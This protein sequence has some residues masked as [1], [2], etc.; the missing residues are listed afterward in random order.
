M[1]TELMHEDLP[2][3]VAPDTSTWGISARLTITARPAI[4]RPRATSRG[5]TA[6]V[7]LRRGQDVAQGHQLPA[8][9]GH[10]HPD[11]RLARDGSQ[12]PDVGRGHGVGDVLRQAT[13]PGPPSRPAPSSSSYRVTVGPTV[14]PTRRVSTPWADR[15]ATRATPPASTSRSSTAWGLACF[16]NVA[17]GSRQSPTVGP[18]F[19]SSCDPLTGWVARRRDQDRSVVG[20]GDDG[21]EL[22]LGRPVGASATTSAGLRR[23]D[24]TDRSVG[25]RRRCRPR[26]PRQVRPGPPR[27]PSGR[28]GRPRRRPS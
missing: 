23:R 28:R 22:G 3:P 6:F 2:E 21:I 25:R 8:A 26:G 27:R 16:S 20:V 17:G 24:R 14:R 4:S 15:A 12:D 1:S 19:I 13:S 7:G 10:L 5:W 11:G 9:V 18:S